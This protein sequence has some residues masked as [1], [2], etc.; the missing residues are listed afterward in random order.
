MKKKRKKNFRKKGTLR[1]SGKNIQLK[2]KI[3]YNYTVQNVG[4]KLFVSFNVNA[5]TKFL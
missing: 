2:Q 3:K 5:R 1:N 4:K